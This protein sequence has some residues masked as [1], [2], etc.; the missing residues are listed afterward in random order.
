[1]SKIGKMPVEI[2]E[3]V[4]VALE[5]R[6]VSVTGP[7]GNFSYT[8]PEGINIKKEDEKL[9]IS[10]ETSNVDKKKLKK[11]SAL[12]GL[13]RA[14]IA[15]YITGVNEG[16]EKKLELSGVGYRAQVAGNDL[17]LS[18]GFSHPVKVS[19]VPGITFKVA[20]NVISIAGSDKS[21]V[22]D[23]AAKIRAI[24]PP[25]PYKGKGISY[26]GERIR[27]KAGKAAKAVGGK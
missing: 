24:R 9:V 13:V 12:S 2:K 15:N 22:G 25:E 16:F 7:K 11:L 23:V 3:G 20:E 5:N 27:R 18:L 1:M 8:L 26:K 19:A 17:V 21:L 14:T 4:N 6:V 10:Q